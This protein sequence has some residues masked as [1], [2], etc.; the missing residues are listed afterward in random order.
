MYIYTTKKH[1][2]NDFVTV[3]VSNHPADLAVAKSYLEDQGISCF[4]KD[5]LIGQIYPLGSNAFGGAKLQVKE[6]DCSH[7]VSL[8]IQGGF[9]KE[10]DYKVPESM[11]RISKLYEKF[12]SLFKRKK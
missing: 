12:S 9:A 3:K 7:A 5:E 11:L 10:E 2:M 4:I 6:S 1:Y 8:L